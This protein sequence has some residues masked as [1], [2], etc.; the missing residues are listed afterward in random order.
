MG[1]RLYGTIALVEKMLRDAG[2][3]PTFAG[4]TSVGGVLVKGGG[5]KLLADRVFT[6]CGAMVWV[7]VDRKTREAFYYLQ[8]LEECDPDSMQRRPLPR[9]II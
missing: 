6:V 1:R 5:Q 4:L 7:G 8:F 3:K 2:Y 9:L